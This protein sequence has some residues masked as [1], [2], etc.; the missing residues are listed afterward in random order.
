MKASD[1]TIIAKDEAEEEQAQEKAAVQ[2]AQKEPVATPK[3]ED[4]GGY[5][6]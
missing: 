6:F 3:D 5:A 4:D 2:A 1:E